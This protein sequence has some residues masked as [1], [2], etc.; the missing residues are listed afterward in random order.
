MGSSNATGVSDGFGLI[1]GIV[2][3]VVLFILVYWVFL[4]VGVLAAIIAGAWYLCTEKGP[5]TPAAHFRA[6]LAPRYHYP[7]IGLGSIA[8]S[9]AGAFAVGEILAGRNQLL[10]VLILAGVLIRAISMAWFPWPRS[11]PRGLRAHPL[12]AVTGPISSALGMLSVWELS[13]GGRP[14]PQSQAGQLGVA[15][16]A[17]L[18][19]VGV[20]LLATVIGRVGREARAS[21]AGRRVGMVELL[22]P[23][24]V[25]L[26]KARALPQYP[27]GDGWHDS[28]RLAPAR[29]IS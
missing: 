5:D 25:E 14:L 29:K 16:T 22:S 2:L 1:V 3:L 8:A 26:G 28:A 10:G 13:G 7:F 23:E 4:I 12:V 15:L 11:Q 17:V 18:M 9:F 27:A 21:A 24:A 20:A 19:S 6:W